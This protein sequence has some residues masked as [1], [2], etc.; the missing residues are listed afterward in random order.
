MAAPD[1]P[2]PLGSLRLR[3]PT[4]RVWTETCLLRDLYEVPLFTDL[5]NARRASWRRRAI[6]GPY[7]GDSGAVR[8]LV[9]VAHIEAGDGFHLNVQVLAVL[10][11]VA[12]KSDTFSLQ[13]KE[14]GARGFR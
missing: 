14:T 3:S 6:P 8:S 2:G 11:S 1:H 10:S 7:S 9:C 5:G 4:W 13:V 12:L